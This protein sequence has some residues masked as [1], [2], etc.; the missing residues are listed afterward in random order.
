MNLLDDFESPSPRPVPGPEAAGGESKPPKG[1]L[2]TLPPESFVQAY[3]D[4]ADTYQYKGPPVGWSADLKR[5]MALPRRTFDDTDPRAAAAWTQHLRRI[6]T[7]PCDCD[8]RWGAK[9]DAGNVVPGSGCITTLNPVQGL[10]LD[11]AYDVKGL[12]GI[13]GVGSGKT[14]LGI[15]LPWALFPHKAA[16][17]SEAKVCLLLI[18]PKL[19]RRFFSKDFPQWSAHFEVPNLAGLSGASWKG[20]GRPVLEVLSYSEL[21]S[22]RNTDIMTRIGPSAIIADEAHKLKNPDAARTKRFFRVFSAEAIQRSGRPKPFYCP[23][24]GTM[25]DKSLKEYAH[26]AEFG[27]VE[28]S[29]LPLAGPVLDSWAAALD[30]SDRPAPPG[31]LRLL[32]AEGETV[33]QGFARR[34]FDTKG[35]ITTSVA[36]SS[37]A[38]EIEALPSPNLP[39]AVKEHL[40]VIREEEKRPDGEESDGAMT[41]ANWARE[42]ASG[43]YSYW[44]FPKEFKRL[45]RCEGPCPPECEA[46]ILINRW[47]A[48]RKAY[49]KSV[50][51][52][53]ARSREFMDSPD[54]LKHAAIRWFEGY[55]HEGVKYPPKTKQRRVPE[56]CPKCRGVGVVKC[57]CGWA[58]VGGPAPVWDSAMVVEGVGMFETWPAWRDV[59]EL[60][61]PEP[62]CKW[63]DPFL[64]NATIAWGKANKGVIWTEHKE[65]GR[66]VAAGLGL[67]FYD[68]GGKDPELDE[69][70]D[71]PV[72]C[73]IRANNEGSNLQ[74]LFFKNLVV[75]PPSAGLLW[76]QLLGRTHRQG[77][78]AETVLVDV[79]LHTAEFRRA[80]DTACQRA[81]YIQT[82]N[83]TP[84][85]LC[86]ATIDLAEA[87]EIE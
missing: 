5:I 67:P 12:L 81:L 51:L 87:A 36:S 17:P 75:H 24:T 11:E 10:A 56:V 62:R 33:Q 76:E 28:S 52:R 68:G 38:L 9:D 80:F 65:F 66:K 22:K 49:N 53:L 23:M 21:S 20:D 35:V 42:M 16:R 27:L 34:L 64:V 78:R 50:R 14:G 19:K 69:K 77:Q 25:T 26:H 86:L 63:V 43:F 39:E 41:T 71:R 30:V 60:V 82:T 74:G 1:L 46:V 18:P 29:P 48:A 2:D 59:K 73:S 31:R 6:R 15:L 7:T 4:E 83:R 54:L 13:L 55:E 45:C 47:F 58:A 57:P 79:F 40:K 3:D 37:A 32:C 70:G 44:A 85:K 8:A 61:E 84:Q 72:V